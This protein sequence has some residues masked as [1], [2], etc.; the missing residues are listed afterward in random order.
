MNLHLETK[1][2]SRFKKCILNFKVVLHGDKHGTYQHTA[3]EHI[4]GL[5]IKYCQ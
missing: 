2:F 1:I 5:H 3:A 4:S